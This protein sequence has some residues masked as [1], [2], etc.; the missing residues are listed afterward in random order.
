MKEVD[1]ILRDLS[2][3]EFKITEHA[4]IRMGERDVSFMDIV[5]V[6]ITASH[7]FWNDQHKAHNIQGLDESGSKLTVSCVLKNE[8][9][10]ITVFY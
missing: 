4:F 10:I 3:G 1:K 2:N 5:N 7:W 8:T 6:G 9:L